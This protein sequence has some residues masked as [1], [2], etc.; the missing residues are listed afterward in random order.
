MMSAVHTLKV[1]S[2]K[3]Q[4]IGRCARPIAVLLMALFQDA[5]GLGE[6]CWGSAYPPGQPSLQIQLQADILWSLA[7]GPDCNLS[8]RLGRG[9]LSSGAGTFFLFST[10]AFRTAPGQVIH[11]H[12]RYSSQSK[13]ATFGCPPVQQCPSRRSAPP[14]P[15][16]AGRTLWRQVLIQSCKPVS[17]DLPD[18]TP[19]WRQGTP[20][21]PIPM[22]QRTT[23][24]FCGNT[25]KGLQHIYQTGADKFLRRK[26]ELHKTAGI[27]TLHPA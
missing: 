2:A 1:V 18:Q 25:G 19:C 10:W 13:D 21:W 22:L 8:R 20:S 12:T 26:D 6:C 17:S 27:R 3:H 23:S 4:L 11:S 15:W 24:R 14:P 7:S 16:L 9:G 5:E